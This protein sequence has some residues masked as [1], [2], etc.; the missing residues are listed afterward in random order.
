MRAPATWYAK[1]LNKRD[2]L[3]LGHLVRKFSID[4]SMDQYLVAG[5]P[6]LYEACRATKFPADRANWLTTQPALP[7]M[8][9][10][11]R[12][13]RAF[14]QGIILP[15][16]FITSGR[17]DGAAKTRMK[18]RLRMLAKPGNKELRAMLFEGEARAKMIHAMRRQKRWAKREKRRS[19]PKVKVI[20]SVSWCAQDGR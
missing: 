17:L 18:K 10:K 6:A 19:E 8:L 9:E 3:F 4:E 20:R 1:D 16:K 5:S 2:Q 14:R 11:P 13:F 15:D 12:W 7:R